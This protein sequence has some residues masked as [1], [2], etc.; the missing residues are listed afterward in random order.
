MRRRFS[1]VPVGSRQTTRGWGHLQNSQPVLWLA[2][3]PDMHEHV[4][5]GERFDGRGTHEP[6]RVRDAPNEM[7][8][9]RLPACGSVFQSPCLY[10]ACW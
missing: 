7:R 1:R 10:C 8:P 4:N 2:T 5:T 9:R 3:V 6:M